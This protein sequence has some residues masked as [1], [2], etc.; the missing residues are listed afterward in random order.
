MRDRNARCL[1]GVRAGSVLVSS[2][3]VALSPPRRPGLVLRRPSRLP[4]Q[5]GTGKIT[6][7]T[8]RSQVLTWRDNALQSAGFE[9]AAPELPQLPRP[10]YSS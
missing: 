1:L 10:G 4:Q 6:F 2:R 7:V 9:A 3:P 8:G 5:V